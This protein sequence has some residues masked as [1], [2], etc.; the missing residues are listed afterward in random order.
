VLEETGLEILN[1]VEPGDDGFSSALSSPTP[2]AACDLIQKDNGSRIE[3]HYSIIE[4][5]RVHH[6]AHA[7]RARA[8]L[9]WRVEWNI[10]VACGV[11]H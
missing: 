11:H 4:V 3:W 2:F 10:E 1:H 6:A 9:K 5:W 7:V 8:T